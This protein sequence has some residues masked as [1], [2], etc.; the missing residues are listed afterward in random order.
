MGK[1]VGNDVFHSRDITNLSGVLRY[2]AELAQ[3]KLPPLELE[4]KVLDGA[5]GGQE[6]TVES[7]VGNLCLVE[8]P[9]EKS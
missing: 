9:G 2:V 3:L 1:R 7:T 6:F 4:A 8:F 5:E